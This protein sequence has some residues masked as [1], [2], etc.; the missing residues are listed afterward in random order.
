MKNYLLLYFLFSLFTISCKKQNEGSKI[1][2]DDKVEKINLISKSSD[3]KYLQNPDKS[4][5]LCLNDIERAK[6]DIKKYHKLY[7]K[8]ICFGCKDKPYDIEIEE[9]LK[10]RKIKKAIQDIGCVV[11]QGQTQGCYMGY[12]QLKMKEKYGENYFLD[13]EKE[14]EDILIKNVTENNKVISIYDLEDKEK[15]QIIDAYIESD[16]YITIKTDLPVTINND[17]SLFA[18]IT[19]IIEKNGTI[20]NFSVSTWVNENVVHEKFK[21]PLIDSAIKALKKDYNHW[22]PGNYKGNKARIEN[23][24]RVSFEK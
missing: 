5:T 9:V 7:V 8:T 17:K 10:K 6:N 21:Q 20:S 19:F 22:K 11:F 13:I 15:P 12:I 4:D 24:L 14:A 2:I 3:P 1:N 18:D 16:Y 23:T